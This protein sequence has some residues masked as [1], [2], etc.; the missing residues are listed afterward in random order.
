MAGYLKSS[1]KTV[2]GRPRL[3]LVSE[4]RV[5]P[6]T[7]IDLLETYFTVGRTTPQEVLCWA[8]PEKDAALRETTAVLI[9]W[10]AQSPAVICALKDGASHPSIPI[11]ALC[12]SSEAEHVAALIVGADDA[13]SYPVSP[14][15][16]QAKLLTYRRLVTPE[17][18]SDE[19]GPERLPEPSP[20]ASP[21]PE[22]HEVCVVGPLTLDRTARHFFACDQ[23]VEL[24]PKE[25]DLMD[26]LMQRV[27]ICLTRN[28]ILDQVWGINF[29]AETNVLG[30]QMYMLR[31]KL[32]T[33]GLGDLIQTVRGVGYRL[34]DQQPVNGT[35]QAESLS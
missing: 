21:L 13:L 9:H 32:A 5:V 28:E 14:V 31:R 25:F 35:W 12:P 33:H 34:V 11:L 30:T 23:E 26:F 7:Q 3:S 19:P 8:P 6:V 15:L 17:P 24:T 1:P 27:G 18:L 2:T 20:S 4:P 22:T 16:L 29:D 10:D